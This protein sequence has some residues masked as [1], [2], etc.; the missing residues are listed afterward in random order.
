M[1]ASGEPLDL[2]SD[3]LLTEEEIVGIPEH[4]DVAPLMLELFGV[5]LPA[6][7]TQGTGGTAPVRV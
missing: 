4:K 1:L 3:K 2:D 7:V 6:A 5:P